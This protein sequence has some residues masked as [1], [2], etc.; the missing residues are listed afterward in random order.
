MDISG[1]KF[2]KDICTNDKF[3]ILVDICIKVLI[4]G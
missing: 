3:A 2:S 4:G 1:L